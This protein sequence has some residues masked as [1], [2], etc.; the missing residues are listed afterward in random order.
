MAKVAVSSASTGPAEVVPSIMVSEA[1]LVI[2]GAL[3]SNLKTE[4]S[5]LWLVVTLLAVV[6]LVDVIVS[7][8]EIAKLISPSL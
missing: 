8:A 3:L 7:E 4:V 1:V 6:T 2:V 5:I